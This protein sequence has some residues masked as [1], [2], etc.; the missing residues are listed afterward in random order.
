MRDITRPATM[1]QTVQ[2][3]KGRSNAASRYLTMQYFRTIGN[4]KTSHNRTQRD[5][6]CIIQ[7]T[8]AFLPKNGIRKAMTTLSATRPVLSRIANDVSFKNPSGRSSSKLRAIGFNNRANLIVLK[9]EQSL[10]RVRDN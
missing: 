5:A 9:E 3:Y 7:K 1:Q 10:Q 8:A 2:K 4:T 6:L